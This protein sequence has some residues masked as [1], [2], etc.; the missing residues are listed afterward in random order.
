LGLGG[1]GKKV[2]VLKIVIF[3][4]GSDFAAIN[5]DVLNS[6]FGDMIELNTYRNRVHEL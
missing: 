5:F 3:E 4:S 2:N 6:Y 1:H